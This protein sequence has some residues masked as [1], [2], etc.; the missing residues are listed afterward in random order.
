MGPTMTFYHATYRHR[1]D[2]IRRHGLTPTVADPNF[3]GA[4]PGVY[5]ASDPM[6]PVAFL[7]EH[8]IENANEKDN[9]SQIVEN[10]VVIVIDD[11]RLDK[12]KLGPDPQLS[13]QEGLWCYR[14]VIDVTNMPIL[15][16][17]TLQLSHLPADHS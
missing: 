2:S 3:P 7:L 16:I 1:L 13:E 10:F 9:P 4:E 11:S 5:L 8:S 17:A 15:D 12:R 6:I 14:G